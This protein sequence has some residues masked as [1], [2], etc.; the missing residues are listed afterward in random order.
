MRAATVTDVG[1]LPTSAAFHHGTIVCAWCGQAVGRK[2]LSGARL[3][4]TVCAPCIHK[5]FATTDA[6]R[7]CQ[8]D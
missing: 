2:P 3:S 1:R 8:L 6:V 7:E 4:H 5:F